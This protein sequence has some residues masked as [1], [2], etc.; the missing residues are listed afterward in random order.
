MTLN[1]ILLPDDKIQDMSKLD[2][3][4]MIILNV[5]WLIEFALKGCKNTMG[6][7]GNCYKEFLLFPH[8]VFKRFFLLV[9]KTLDKMENEEENI[10]S[11]SSNVFKNLILLG[12][13]R[14]RLYRKG[15]KK[16]LYI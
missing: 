10:F 13:F 12:S 11:L 16:Y 8:N 9:I 2:T 15:L 4:Q 14:A 6:N 7:E 1:V 3:Q 5:V